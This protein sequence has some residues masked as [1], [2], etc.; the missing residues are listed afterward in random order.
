MS[1]LD[2]SFRLDRLLIVL[3]RHVATNIRSFNLKCS[4]TRG[5]YAFICRLPQCYDQNEHVGK[6]SE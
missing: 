4:V 2:G 1:V 5:I 6:A 3:S